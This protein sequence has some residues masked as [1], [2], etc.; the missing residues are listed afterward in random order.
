M[1]SAYLSWLAAGLGPAGPAPRRAHPPRRQGETLVLG[2]AL[3]YGPRAIKVF[4]ASLRAEHDGPVAI[5]TDR[6]DT[7]GGL[8]AR[9]GVD[10]LE[11]APVRGYRPHPNVAR[12]LA[13]LRA[14]EN[15]YPE[16]QTILL[17]DVRDVVF[18][19]DPLRPAPPHLCFFCEASSLT[20]GQHAANRRWLAR[21]VGEEIARGLADRPCV[22]A[23]TLLGPRAAMLRLLRQILLLLAIPRSAVAAAFGADQ[24]AVNLIAHWGLAGEA[25]ILP[26][27]R[28]VATIGLTA[29]GAVSLDPEGRIRNPD[30]SISA[31]VHQY[32]RHP[33]LRAAIEARWAVAEEPE[34][35]MA[36]ARQGPLAALAKRLPE[37][38]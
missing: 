24:A 20:I 19:A 17:S 5:L 23:G 1:A 29:P 4:L 11:A 22:C 30:G 13:F 25:E 35:P 26:N 21:C 18:Q 36:P 31:L 12:F 32:D 3:G 15:H 16:A 10:C 27:F 7:V 14:I 34:V 28:R 37:L 33:A 6:P 9:F 2:A 8:L 38:R